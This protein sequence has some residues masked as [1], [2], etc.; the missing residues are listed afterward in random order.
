MSSYGSNKAVL[1]FATMQLLQ[2]DSAGLAT[3]AFYDSV[4]QEHCQSDKVSVRQLVTPEQFSELSRAR[5]RLYGQR[6]VYYRTLFGDSVDETVCLDEYDSRSYVFA[7]YY[8]GDIIGTQRI[9]PF[10]HES[11]EYI[12]H[13]RLLKF[14]GPGARWLQGLHHLCEAT[15]G[16]KIRELGVRPGRHPVPDPRPWRALL[17]LVQGR[18]VA[19]GD[20]VLRPGSVPGGPQG[21]RCADALHT[22]RQ[23][24]AV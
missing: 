11:G 8:D 9:T 10:P 18:T 13:Q 23:A 4:V 17:R 5:Y 12:E 21:H 3:Q 14:S 22:G 1:P 2:D 15:P 16:A 20:P 7:C 6:K 19:F 24:L